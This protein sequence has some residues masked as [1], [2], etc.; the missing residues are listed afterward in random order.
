MD[1]KE[2]ERPVWYLKER[3]WREP[4]QEKEMFV[5]FLRRGGRRRRIKWPRKTAICLRICSLGILQ[6]S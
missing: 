6:S 5:L 2:K 4:M 1:E 3:A